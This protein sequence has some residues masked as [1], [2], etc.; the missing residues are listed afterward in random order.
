[1][2][3][4]GGRREGVSQTIVSSYVDL[5]KRVFCADSTDDESSIMIE[6][7]RCI[8]SMYIQYEPCFHLV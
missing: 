6:D 7:Y 5:Q 1:V 4:R 2:W 8:Y 3:A